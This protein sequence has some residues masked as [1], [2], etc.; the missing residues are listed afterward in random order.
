MRFSKLL[1]RVA[2]VATSDLDEHL[3]DIFNTHA[4]FISNFIS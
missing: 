4:D 2:R 3:W 1:A